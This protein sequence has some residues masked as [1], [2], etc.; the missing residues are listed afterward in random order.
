[1]WLDNFDFG[2]KV[3]TSEVYSFLRIFRPR[4]AESLAGKMIE[5]TQWINCN[6]WVWFKL[7]W[8]LYKV[9]KSVSEGMVCKDTDGAVKRANQ[10]VN[11]PIAATCTWSKIWGLKNW[12]KKRLNMIQGHEGKFAVLATEWHKIIRKECVTFYDCERNNMFCRPGFLNVTQ[13]W[14]IA[15]RAW[16]KL[17]PT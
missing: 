12:R 10:L 3:I 1:M 4:K 13:K 8:M 11:Q 16:V 5:I 2:K 7:I 6:F 15:K 14:P 9:R 17:L